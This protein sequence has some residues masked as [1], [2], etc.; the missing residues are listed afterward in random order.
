MVFGWLYPPQTFVSRTDKKLEKEYIYIEK[1]LLR[2]TEGQ[3][4]GRTDE[5]LDMHIAHQI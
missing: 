3:T 4:D 5:Q 2:Q 1:K